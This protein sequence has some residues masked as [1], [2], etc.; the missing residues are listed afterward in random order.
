MS[1][2]FLWVKLN[3]DIS[4]FFAFR[5]NNLLCIS[6][7]ETFRS[8]TSPYNWEVLVQARY[9]IGE[10]L[11]RKSPI[12]L[13]QLVENHNSYLD[14]I[15]RDSPCTHIPINP[16]FTDDQNPGVITDGKRQVTAMKM[17]VDDNLIT[18]V[19]PYI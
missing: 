5:I 7:G 9:L 12:H 18:E 13:E 15:K 11:L 17:H 10:A 16:A 19:I 1:S 3:P 6:T 8:N 4:L 14:M 2:S